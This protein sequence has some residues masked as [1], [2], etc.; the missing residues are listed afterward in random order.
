M[1]FCFFFIS[2]SIPSPRFTVCLDCH[3]MFLPEKGIVTWDGIWSRFLVRLR[4]LNVG[5]TFWTAERPKN[6]WYLKQILLRIS[7]WVLALSTCQVWNKSGHCDGDYN[8]AHESDILCWCLHLLLCLCT[9]QRYSRLWFGMP[10]LGFSSLHK[11]AVSWAS[12][13]K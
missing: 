4:D 6:S 12:K 8:M 1:S 3:R 7:R 5:I 13:W 9:T 10:H 2:P 11:Y